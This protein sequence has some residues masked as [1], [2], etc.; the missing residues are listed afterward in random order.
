M[1]AAVAE[2]LWQSDFVR[3][4]RGKQVHAINRDTIDFVSQ[5]TKW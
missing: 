3:S 5:F 2:V 4:E 1:R